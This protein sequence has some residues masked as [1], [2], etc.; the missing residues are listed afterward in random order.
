[1]YEVDQILDAHAPWKWMTFDDCMPF[2]VTREF[3]SCCKQR[4]A[5]EKKSK[6]SGLLSDRCNYTKARN[7]VTN[8]KKQVKRDHFKVAFEN[9][10]SDPKKLWRVI[11]LLLGSNHKKSK[12][13]EINGH[14]DPE[15][16]ANEINNYFADIGGNL[17]AKIP[18]SLLEL[19][20]EFKDKCGY[21]PLSARCQAA[22]NGL[23]LADYLRKLQCDSLHI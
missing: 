17:A 10:G 8:F 2:W 7:R 6:I 23:H 3:L 19:D 4:D 15:Q 14:S 1:M 9:A 13:S 21:L 18:D 12:I 16:M 5:L 11:K 22:Y 20:L